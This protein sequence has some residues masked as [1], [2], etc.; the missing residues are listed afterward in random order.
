MSIFTHFHCTY[1][2]MVALGRSL[3]ET[4]KWSTIMRWIALRLGSDTHGPQ[5]MNCNK[6]GD[7]LTFSLSLSGH[8]ISI[9]PILYDQ[10]Q[11]NDIPIILSCA[12]SLVFTISNVRKL[13]PQITILNTKTLSLP[14][15]SMLALPVSMLTLA[16]SWGCSFQLLYELNIQLTVPMINR[17]IR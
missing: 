8:F 5:R 2:S 3:F 13:T 9:W 1:A 17:V 6:C 10:L 12:L 11:I 16:F 7:P 14:S 4:D 15:I